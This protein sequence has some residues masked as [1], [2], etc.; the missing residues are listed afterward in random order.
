MA[1]KVVGD[2]SGNVAE[3][4]SVKN[5]LVTTPQSVN[6]TNST[7]VGYT[8]LAV[9]PQNRALTSVG[10]NGSACYWRSDDGVV[11]PD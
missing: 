2:T 10:P 5:L 3:V 9:G 1:W 6:S 8:F 4:D 11:R 7:K